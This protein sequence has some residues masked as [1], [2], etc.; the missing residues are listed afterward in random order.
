MR[1]IKSV[2]LAVLAGSLLTGCSINSS[3]M[4]RTDKNFVSQQDRTI[5][6]VEYKIAPNDILSVSVYTNEGISLI[7]LTAHSNSLS[8]TNSGNTAFNG[9][10]QYT[11]DIDGFVK[12]P[13]IG[14]VKI[15]NMTTREAEVLLEKQYTTYYNKPFVMVKVLNRR[16]LVFPGEGG[17]GK[18]VTLT[19]DNTTL[20]E[21]LALAGGVSQYGIAKRIKLIR[22]DSRNPQ[23]SIIDLSTIDGMKASNLLL[24]ANDIIYVEPRKRVSQGVLAEIAPIVGIFS[25]IA[26]IFI[27]YD[28]IRRSR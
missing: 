3:I 24:Q 13:I 15:Q 12:L 5:G 20:I 8:E 28:V 9:L 26:S 2:M 23:V 17:A 27:A 22:G 16:V 4:F 1:K 25:G 14:R 7:D 6:N 21:A 18:V 10:N 11:V 19:N